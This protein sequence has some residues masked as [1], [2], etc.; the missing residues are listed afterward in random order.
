[1]PLDEANFTFF[2]VGTSTEDLGR[3]RFQTLAPTLHQHIWHCGKLPFGREDTATSPAK[4]PSSMNWLA[5][6]NNAGGSADF[7][8]VAHKAAR[9][10][11]CKLLILSESWRRW[12]LGTEP[13]P[14]LE[15]LVLSDCIQ[16]PQ[17]HKNPILRQ[18]FYPRLILGHCAPIIYSPLHTNLSWKTWAK[19]ASQNSPSKST[20]ATTHLI[21]PCGIVLRIFTQKKNG[22]LLCCKP[23]DLFLWNFFSRFGPR[24]GVGWAVTV[25]GHQHWGSING[26][27]S[28]A[29]I[30]G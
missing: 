14:V 27:V 25:R 17:N 23:S 26:S 30:P 18:P 21:I 2:S 1:M 4:L 11:V 9:V 19:T 20:Q 29:I 22:T 3:S 12:G 5:I 24:L 8:C 28:I 7:L 15:P 10:G 6:H 13:R 16:L